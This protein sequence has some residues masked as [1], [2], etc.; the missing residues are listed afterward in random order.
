MGV[1]PIDAKG[2]IHRSNCSLLC[3]HAEQPTDFQFSPF[4]PDLFSSASRTENVKI[5]SLRNLKIPETISGDPVLV[6]P[7]SG[8]QN[9]DSISF[10]PCAQHLLAVGGDSKISLFD[11][12]SGK[13]AKN[14]N[15]ADRIQ[16]IS[17]APDGKLLAAFDRSKTVQIF[18]PRAGA[19]AV[20]SGAGPQGLGK[21]SR[22][23][24]LDE[25]KIL[26]SGFSKSRTAEIH[27]FDTQC[28]QKPLQI[29]PLQGTRQ[30][31]S[32]EIF[33]LNFFLCILQELLQE[34]NIQ[35]NI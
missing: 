21:E 18:D 34:L 24:F 15:S 28:P 22:V 13:N 5:W 17:W 27:V 11:I 31:F 29:L 4:D 19:G 10:N 2:R 26:V 20:S 1:L 25:F 33:C 12:S 14:F 32:I 30:V 7:T 8:V 16:T 35:L 9:V 3:A 6:L 23:R